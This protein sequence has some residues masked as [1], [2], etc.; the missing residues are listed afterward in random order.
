VAT[1]RPNASHLRM[2]TH[3][4]GKNVG[5][6]AGSYSYSPNGRWIVFRFKNPDREEFRMLKMHPNGTHRKLIEKRLPFATRNLDWG[7]HKR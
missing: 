2:L 7:P 4:K 6:L 1:V 3:Y 5:A